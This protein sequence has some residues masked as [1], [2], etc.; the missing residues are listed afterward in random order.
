MRIQFRRLKIWGS[1]W[2]LWKKMGTIW[3]TNQKIKI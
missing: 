1:N 2:Y 3:R